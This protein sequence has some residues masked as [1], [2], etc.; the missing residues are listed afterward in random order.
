MTDRAAHDPMSQSPSATGDGALRAPPSEGADLA[1]MRAL[2]DRPLP[3]ERLAENTGLVAAPA[4][5]EQGDT[6]G[7]LVFV[8]GDERLAIEADEAHR[9]FRATPV[10]RIPHRSNEV[11]E[12]IANIGGELTLVARLAAALGLPAACGATHFV[13]IGASAGRWAFA[14]DRV[15][16]VRR[17]ERSRLLP[18]PAT[19]RHAADGC[20]VAIAVERDG[21]APIAVLDAGRVCAL[22]ARSLA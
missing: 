18:A 8:L 21:G 14:V 7:I 10:G 5:R 2:L 12:G 4:V 1:R 19:V 6:M 11:L 13:V 22:L 20:T 16:G 15:E 3:P 17:I 9:V